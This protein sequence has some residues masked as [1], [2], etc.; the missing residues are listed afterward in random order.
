MDIEVRTD[1][2]EYIH[3][4][5][6]LNKLAISTHPTINDHIAMELITKEIDK[7]KYNGSWIW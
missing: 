7:R 2:I 3:Q 1:N 4:Y 5:D 6:L